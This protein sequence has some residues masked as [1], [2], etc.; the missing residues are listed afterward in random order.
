M[1]GDRTAIGT[2]SAFSPPIDLVEVD[3][4]ETGLFGDATK[5]LIDF[6]D[7]GLDWGE[8]KDGETEDGR[9]CMLV[10]RRSFCFEF[11]RMGR[12]GSDSSGWYGEK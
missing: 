9:I 5:V 3:A 1:L 2:T 10:G 6:V 12:G 7:V 8:A 4:V 11:A